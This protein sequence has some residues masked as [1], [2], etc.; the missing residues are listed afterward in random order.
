MWY[1]HREKVNIKNI[2][3]NIKMILLFQFN[4]I[5]TAH[6]KKETA[7][8]NVRKSKNT[9]EINTITID[10]LIYITSFTS[11][12]SIINRINKYEINI[13]KQPADSKSSPNSAA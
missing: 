3:V 9:I 1:F 12:M 10:L 7:V 5:Y 4:F 6:L 11:Y 2:K 8:H 13:N